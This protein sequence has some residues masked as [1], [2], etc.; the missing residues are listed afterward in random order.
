MYIESILEFA[1]WWAEYAQNSHRLS[2][3]NLAFRTSLACI[4][5]SSSRKSPS[6][7]AGTAFFCFYWAAP[8]DSNSEWV[9]HK[10]QQLL[11]DSEVV[12]PWSEVFWQ[13]FFSNA[14]IPD[15][16]L[17]FVGTSC[18]VGKWS[19]FSLYVFWKALT[20]S[21]SSP[22][23]TL[24]LQVKMVQVTSDITQKCNLSHRFVTLHKL[25]HLNWVVVSFRSAKTRVGPTP[26]SAIWHH[27]AKVGLNIEL[28]APVVVIWKADAVSLKLSKCDLRSWSLCP[29]VLI[30][31]D[32]L[33]HMTVWWMMQCSE[34]TVGW[35][36]MR[37]DA[38]PLSRPITEGPPSV[39]SAVWH[40]Q[41]Y[42]M[43]CCS[44]YTCILQSW[45]QWTFN[46]FLL[47]KFWT[48]KTKSKP[49]HFITLSEPVLF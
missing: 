14:T 43:S 35:S 7:R 48:L 5:T 23:F 39:T 12:K 27:C 41:L 6:L 10:Q 3:L 42:C 49:C 13:I 8:S 16:T 4:W 47:A 21:K 31:P 36:D 44:F 25:R 18:R 33:A 2:S 45:Q 46:V 15:S 30:S 11:W 1:Y 17:P 37:C 26:C 22:T 29:S 24:E 32:S 28:L 38:K 34:L 40:H 20:F 9:T 19:F